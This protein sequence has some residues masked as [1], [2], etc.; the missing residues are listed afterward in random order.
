MKNVLNAVTAI[1]VI[2]FLGWQFCGECCESECVETKCSKEE[3]ST[4]V[5]L[6]IQTDNENIDIDSI[7]DAVL[8]DI[9]ME[10][11]IDTIIKINID[12]TKED[13]IEST[14]E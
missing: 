5:K 10:G 2:L 4:E 3:I 11:D 1:L 6:D 7:V 12:L 14:E 13:E 8:E 9:D